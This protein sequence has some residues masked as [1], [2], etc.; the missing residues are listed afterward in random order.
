MKPLI[1]KDGLKV[2]VSKS[3]VSLL[4]QADLRGKGQRRS[5]VAFSKRFA[6]R[7]MT[8]E[9]LS[10]VLTLAYDAGLHAGAS[11]PYC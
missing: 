1:D 7:Q 3:G 2:V 9:E 5:T 8:H 10:K 11:N 6:L 4:V